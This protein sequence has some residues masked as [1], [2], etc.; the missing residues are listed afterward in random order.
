[1]RRGWS[2]EVT[3]VDLM[4]VVAIIGILA[5]IAIPNFMK[6][7][8][9]IKQSEVKSNLRSL[10]TADRAYSQHFE[11]YTDLLSHAGFAPERGNRNLN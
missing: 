4:I 8:A 7:Q 10:Y 1:M 11:S 2:K 6:S 9:P 3:L 5:V